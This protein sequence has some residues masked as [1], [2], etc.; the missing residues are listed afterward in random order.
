[1]S[2]IEKAEILSFLRESAADI[3]ADAIP[4]D[5]GAFL[6]A[7]LIQDLGCDSLDMI[8]LLFQVEERFSITVPEPDIDSENLTNTG[9][10]VAYIQAKVE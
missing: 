6:A 8:N 5:E 3:C 7:D 4:H 2:S 10:L 1:V 9:N